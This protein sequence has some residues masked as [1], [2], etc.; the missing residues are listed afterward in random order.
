V[1]VDIRARVQVFQ[2]DSFVRGP[3][4]LSTMFS[5]VQVFKQLLHQLPSTNRFSMIL[6]NLVRR[7]VERSSQDWSTN[8]KGKSIEITHDLR[9]PS[10]LRWA[11]SSIYFQGLPSP[12]TG[13]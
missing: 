9:H 4:K 2:H 13:L 1:A 5:K 7:L 6:P 12:I 8:R 3:A 10:Y 11:A